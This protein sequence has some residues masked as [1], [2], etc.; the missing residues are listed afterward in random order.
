MSTRLHQLYDQFGQSPWLD[1]LRRDWLD[2]GTIVTWVERGVRGIT[3]NPSIFA[4]AIGGSDDYDEQLAA[5]LRAGAT[6]TDAYWDLVCTDVLRALDVLRPLHDTSGG[7]DGFVSVEVDPALADDTAGTVAAARAL[8][9]RLDRPNLF[10]KV[11]A[12][13]AGIPAIRTLI[14]EGISVN[15]TLIFAIERYREVME[16]YIA[17]LEAA[18]DRFVPHVRSVASFFVSRVDGEV[19]KALDAIGSPEALGIRGKVAV[20]NAQ[21]AYDEFVATFAGDRWDALVRR[22]AHVQRPLWASTSTKNPAYPDT[23]YVDELIG[24]ASVNTLPDDTLAAFLDH[25]TP[26]RTIDRDPAAARAVLAACRS[27]GVDLDGITDRLEVDGVASFR[28]SF[29]D[30]ITALGAKAERLGVS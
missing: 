27:V 2:A 28:T 17:G 8:A 13:R 12:T 19:D 9:A 3:S 29:D 18:Q 14:S 10:V 6:V 4:K 20:A 30:L 7:E 26:A 24:P 1:N 23:L 25:G 11:P 5:S 21:V 22:G 15:V 16:A